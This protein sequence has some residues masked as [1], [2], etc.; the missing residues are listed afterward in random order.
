VSTRLT[1]AADQ[2]ESD[3][4]HVFFDA[5]DTPPRGLV[6]AELRRVV[7]A[8]LAVRADGAGGHLEFALAA[9]VW[10][11]LV[12]AVAEA[13]AL[14]RDHHEGLPS[15]TGEAAVLDPSWAALVD[16][17]AAEDLR[18]VA[19]F[20]RERASEV[21][22]L[23]SVVEQTVRERGGVLAVA[24]AQALRW[25]TPLTEARDSARQRERASQGAEIARLIRVTLATDAGGVR[26]LLSRWSSRLHCSA[27]DVLRRGDVS[28]LRRLLDET[29]AEADRF[30]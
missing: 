2:S 21:A 6:H 18:A 28:E 29:A 30:A 16:D 10:W 20:A 4:W 5:L 27:F 3:L 19:Q 11:A 8:Q 1:I 23:Q 14:G 13:R 12:R 7:D 9:D 17:A 15:T 26:W 22:W 24:C 25:T